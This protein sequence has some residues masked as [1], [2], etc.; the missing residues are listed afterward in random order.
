[1]S[2]RTYQ[3]SKRTRKN[4]FGFRARMAT[5][6]GRDILR[7]RRQ[8]GRKRLVPKGVELKFERHSNQYNR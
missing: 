3:P 1:M 7:R 5:K 6:A 4:Q 2:K 8:K